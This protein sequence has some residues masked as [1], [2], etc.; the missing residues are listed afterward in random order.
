MNKSTRG[1]RIFIIVLFLFQLLLVST[2]W[3]KERTVLETK[4]SDVQTDSAEKTLTSGTLYYAVTDG[5]GTP[6]RL[7]VIPQF[8][9]TWWF[10]ISSVL[11]ILGFL[12]LFYQKGM[13]FIVQK[14]SRRITMN[15]FCRKFNLSK[16][17]QEIVRLLLLGESQKNIEDK[18]FISYHTVKNHVYNI[19]RK[20]GINN[21]FQLFSLFQGVRS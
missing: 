8:W 10:K 1:I 16:R 21:R 5:K 15:D 4:G 13:K 19:Y 12:F 9:N 6:I 14:G 11:L 3:T 7:V 18:L 2:S 20:L 17:E